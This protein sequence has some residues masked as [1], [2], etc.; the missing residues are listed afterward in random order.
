MAKYKVTGKVSKP[1]LGAAGTVTA[2]K[3]VEATSED[4]AKTKAKAKW[5]GSYDAIITDGNDIMEIKA[6]AI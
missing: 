4:D 2:T 5:L 6:V 1:E 3:I